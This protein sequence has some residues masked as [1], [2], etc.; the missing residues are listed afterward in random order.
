M[1]ICS[2]SACSL[3][4]SKENQTGNTCKKCGSPLE[5]YT[6][7]NS[8]ELFKKL[9]NFSLI[10]FPKSVLLT[11][12]GLLVVGILSYFVYKFIG[13]GT[14]KS[15]K[16]DMCIEDKALDSFKIIQL[17]NLILNE[18]ISEIDKFLKQFDNL[19]VLDY[20]NTTISKEKINKDNAY[21][22]QIDEL[23]LCT[24]T[25]KITLLP[26]KEQIIAYKNGN[27]LDKLE[28]YISETNFNVNSEKASIAD[29]LKINKGYTLILR[30]P[31]NGKYQNV[32]AFIENSTKISIPVPTPS[33]WKKENVIVTLPV[34]ENEKHRIISLIEDLTDLIE[35]A[36]VKSLDKERLT[37]V[38]GDQLEG[39]V[40]V[41]NKTNYKI[42]DYF[43]NL[44]QRCPSCKILPIECT[45]KLDVIGGENQN[46]Y[47][48]D[49]KV[50]EYQK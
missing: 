48:K 6:S 39:E 33:Q 36:Q 49:I 25:L 11:L 29:W 46:I 18:N 15:N 40:R 30:N 13:I 2:N 47:F 26:T 14:K 21:T 3:N 37:L 31:M 5:P 34:L 9:F 10:K 42:E 16:I 50:I 32:E 28:K 38:F 24:K 20:D 17:K 44:H 8:F 35:E 22:W 23:N 7:K 27:E 12:L 4:K 19:I 1:Q 41:H 43:N 45:P